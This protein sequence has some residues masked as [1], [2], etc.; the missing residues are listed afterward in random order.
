MYIDWNHINIKTQN[1][2]K[3]LESRISN[4]SKFYYYY[5]L[6]G[7]HEIVSIKTDFLTFYPCVCCL[8]EATTQ[9]LQAF[10]SILV[11][12]NWSKSEHFSVKNMH[13]LGSWWYDVPSKRLKAKVL[14][15]IIAVCLIWICTLHKLQHNTILLER[16]LLHCSKMHASSDFDEN[17]KAKLKVF[18]L[19]GH[20][21]N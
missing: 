19:K 2:K 5:S 12:A 11:W 4:I 21:Q 6:Q 10:N 15:G 7:I 3:L 14:F 13:C 16:I 1:V 9:P 8:R 17:F 20:E 18:G